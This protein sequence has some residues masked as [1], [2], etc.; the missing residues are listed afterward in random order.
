MFLCV[1]CPLGEF[2][3]AFDDPIL[4]DAKYMYT[5]IGRCEMMESDMMEHIISYW[6]DDPGM[7][8][9]FESGS[10]VLMSPHTIPVGF[11]KH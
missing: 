3:N 4:I 5:V 9:M 1:Q 2:S 10:R 6:K 7:K 11:F 8:H